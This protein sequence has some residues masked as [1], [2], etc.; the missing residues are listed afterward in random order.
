MWTQKYAPARTKDIIGNKSN[1]DK[2][3]SWLSSWS[4]K[5]NSG[6]KG[7]QHAALLSGP[8]GIG[9]TSTAFVVCKT[10]GYDILEFNASDTRSK[11]SLDV[12]EVCVH[13]FVVN[14]GFLATCQGNSP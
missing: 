1:V 11:K 10:L 2:L 3:E 14:F 4:E 9:K 12:N 5:R 8:P 7:F 13:L 6:E